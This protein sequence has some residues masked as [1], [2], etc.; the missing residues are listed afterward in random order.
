MQP[1]VSAVVPAHG[2][3]HLPDCFKLEKDFSAPA[4]FLTSEYLFSLWWKKL[5]GS[6][7]MESF[8]G[9]STRAIHCLSPSHL[10]YLYPSP[11]SKMRHR[12]PKH[13]LF[14]AKQTSTPTK[15]SLYS[16]ATSNLQTPNFLLVVLVTLLVP[17]LHVPV[18]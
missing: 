1:P 8:S 13:C 9:N 14:F 12:V 5:G 18:S 17:T 2:K 16:H 10:P 7:G 11:Q 15:L 3:A 6:G 4:L